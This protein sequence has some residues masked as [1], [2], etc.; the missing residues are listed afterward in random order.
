LSKM[1]FRDSEMPALL[2]D[3]G[4]ALVILDGQRHTIYKS[5]RTEGSLVF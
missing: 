2:D 3:L 1:L 5:A 4:Q